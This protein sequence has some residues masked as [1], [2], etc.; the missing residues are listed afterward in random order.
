MQ[1]RKYG[2]W[3]SPI[4]PE[5][6][7]QSSVRLQDLFYDP[8]TSAVYHIEGR[9]SEKGR[10]VIVGRQ[11]LEDGT[12]SAAVDVNPPSTNARTGVHEY[13]GAPAGARGGI[14]VFTDIVDRRLF[15]LKTGAVLEN[16][17]EAQPITPENKSARFADINIHPQLDHLVCV[18]ENHVSEHEVINS[19]VRVQLDSKSFKISEPVEIAGGNDFYSGCRF[20]PDGKYIAWITWNHPNMNWTK[21]TLM[22]AEWDPVKQVL[23][24]API[25]LTS[26]DF[27][28]SQPRWNGEHLYFASDKTG[29]YNLYK[30]NVKSKETT[31]VLASA[32]SGDFSSPDWVFGKTTYDFLADGQIVASY[33]ESGVPKIALINPLTK[34]VNVI[35][36]KF[37]VSYLII[38]KDRI[39]AFAGTTTAPTALISMEPKK[40]GAVKV[41]RKSID[42]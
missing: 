28:V 4:Q 24:G 10:A 14:L 8:V 11:V 35:S 3:E 15:A 27:S 40:D 21:S 29:F 20:S 30:Y 25:A 33:S 32:V 22:V 23:G 38:V 41:L 39:F 16:G 12:L 2:L 34:S 6:L 13:G 18:Y 26:G 9:P 17:A 37:K 7:T 31:P 36:T 19:L 42:M 5:S 1:T